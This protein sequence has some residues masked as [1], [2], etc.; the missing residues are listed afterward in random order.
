MQEKT[1]IVD[2]DHD[3]FRLDVFLSEITGLS[4]SQIKKYID[5]SLVLIHNTPAKKSGHVVHEG[6]S[7]ILLPFVDTTKEQSEQQ[8]GD[9]SLYDAIRVVHKDP[10][11]LVVFKPAGLLVHPTEAEEQVTLTAWLRIHYPDVVG[12]GESEDRPGIVHRLDRHASGLLV[13]ARTQQMYLHLKSQFKARSVKK[14]YTVLVHGIIQ[15]N[16]GMIDFD[17][18]RGHDGRMVARPKV[19]EITLNTVNDI[20]SGRTSLTEFTVTERF[21]RFTLLNVR[22]HSGRT[23]QIRVHMFA[24]THPVVGDTLYFNKNLVKKSDRPLDRM[25]LHAQKLCFSDLNNKEKCFESPLPEEL[26]TY[27]GTLT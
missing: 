5:R 22:I 27:L 26:I 16:H 19:K 24:Y 4:R 17:I 12:V 25:F 9:I 1:Y 21:G 2:A 23:H 3:G 14:E 20:Q 10:S 6:I 7:V 11:Y 8:T 15:Q 13:I 18:D